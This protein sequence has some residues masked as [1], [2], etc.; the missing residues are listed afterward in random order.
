MKMGLDFKKAYIKIYDTNLIQ[1][2]SRTKNTDQI[3][4]DGYIWS[5][6]EDTPWF[7]SGGWNFALCVRLELFKGYGE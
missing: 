5:V 3:I 2:L 7:M 6:A 1:T 4:Y